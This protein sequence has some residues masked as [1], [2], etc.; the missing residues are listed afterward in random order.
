MTAD[1]LRSYFG[2]V[3]QETVLYSGTILDNLRMGA[4]SATE[5]DVTA[6]CK[7]VGLHEAIAAL[8]EGYDTI[9]GERG[10]GL[11]GGQKQRLAI[12]R[13]LLKKPRIL[14]F[15]EATSSLDEENAAAV[16]ET[17]N[18]LRGAATIVF[19]GHNIP[20][21]LVADRRVEIIPAGGGA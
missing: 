10:I 5:A 15:D 20:A 19:I 8:P 2:V 1:R 18:R 21:N 16:A 14:L 12:A 6:V 4:A 17:V 13:A 11:S 3:P 9:I 7:W